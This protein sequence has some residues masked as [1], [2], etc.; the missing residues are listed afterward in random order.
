MKWT[1]N[2]TIT[3][4]FTIDTVDYVSSRGRLDNTAIHW[5]V[6]F[7]AATKDIE[8]NDTRDIELERDKK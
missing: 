6:I 2:W 5:T 1:F 3:K 8:S 7:S 4:S